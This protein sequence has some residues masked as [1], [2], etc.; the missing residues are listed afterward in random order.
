[1]FITHRM[2]DFPRIQRLPH[3]VFNIV[4][5][6]KTTARAR[7]EDIID[8]GMGNPDQPTPQPIVD[9]LCEAA[10]RPDTHR[11]SVSKGIPR[12]RKAISNWYGR[13]FNVDIDPDTE[14]IVTIG[15]KEGLAHLAMATMDKGDSVLVSNPA[16]PVHPYGFIIAGADIRHVPIGPDI[17]FFVEL[18]AAVKNSYPKP[19]MLVLNFPSNPTTQCVD[20]EFFEKIIEM[21]IEHQF[22]VVQDLAYA[23]IVYDGYI[24]P[25]IMQ[26]A[27]AKDI[28]VES[29]SLSKSYNMPGWR[30]GFLVGNKQLIAA[31]ARLKSYLDYGMFAPIQIAS[32]FALEAQEANEW[33][34]EIRDRYQN[35][36]DILCEG[37]NAAGWSVHKPRATMFVWAKIPEQ[38]AHLKSME[39]SKLLLKEA[40]VA[41][42]P[43]IGFGD[44]GDSYVR[45][46]LI[47]NEQRIRQAI[48]G[49]KSLLSHPERI[50][51]AG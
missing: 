49:I 17:D 33:I 6:L 23:D 30:V 20:L 3:Y 16:Y 9:K 22:W 35:R 37:L 42:S 13:R 10:Q 48:R 39:F 26:V 19:K 43:G 38:F 2:D 31:L 21:A 28:A 44:Y 15:S 1:M 41:V 18:E 34:G 47:E 8:F 46:G 51:Q 24:A 27:G 5:D 45:F 14:A 36:R 29:Y 40:K 50:E 25:S 4:G 11:Y 32:I 12:L 7:G